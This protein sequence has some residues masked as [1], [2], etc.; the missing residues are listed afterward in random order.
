[1]SN[2]LSN[3]LGQ[4]APLSKKREAVMMM[5]PMSDSQILGLMACFLAR[6]NSAEEAVAKAVE[7]HSR[8]MVFGQG[9]ISR[10][11]HLLVNEAKAAKKA[12]DDAAEKAANP[13]GV[14]IG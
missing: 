9:M 1:M 10:A 13:P 14:L 12:A 8:V 5:T 7:I 3:L 11:C 6:D 4:A 2:N